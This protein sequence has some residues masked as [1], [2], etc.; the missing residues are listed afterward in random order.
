MHRLYSVLEA[1][2]Y[3][4]P[5]HP[6]FTHITIGM[7]FGACLLGLLALC[8]HSDSLVRRQLRAPYRLMPSFKA[9][10]SDDEVYD[11]IVFLPTR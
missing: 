2:G 3:P 9:K 8:L 4:H 10:V 5:L 11:L 7:V 6:R 1:S